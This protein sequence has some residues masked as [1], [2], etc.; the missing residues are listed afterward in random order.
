[1]VLY[2]PLHASIGATAQ[3]AAKRRGSDYGRGVD[4]LAGVTL[5]HESVV[6]RP[7]NRQAR[8]QVERRTS[9]LDRIEP[10]DPKTPQLLLEGCNA[11]RDR[12]QLVEVRVLFA[13]GVEDAL[14]AMW[15]SAAVGEPA[16]GTVVPIGNRVHRLKWMRPIVEVGG[17]VRPGRCCLTAHQLGRQKT[18]QN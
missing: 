4:R 8:M 6:R 15:S 17:S 18:E 10:P 11:L 2:P 3:V 9:G 5:H 1:V 13:L 16:H 14:E 7:I 12:S